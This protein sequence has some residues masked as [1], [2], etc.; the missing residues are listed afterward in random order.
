MG[1]LPKEPATD[2]SLDS[3]NRQCVVSAAQVDT[4][5]AGDQVHDEESGS[6]LNDMVNNACCLLCQ[7]HDHVREPISGGD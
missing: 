7:E 6:Q 2:A 3:A 5:D 4:G 1:I